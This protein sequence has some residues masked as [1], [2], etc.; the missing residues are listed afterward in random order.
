M[1]NVVDDDAEMDDVEAVAVAEE[2]DTALVAVCNGD[3]SPS[4][5]SVFSLNSVGSSIWYDYYYL[6]SCDVIS[7]QPPS[8]IVRS[9]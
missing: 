2:L 8:S 1:V 4:N 9:S 3:K 6:Q 7:L 5:A